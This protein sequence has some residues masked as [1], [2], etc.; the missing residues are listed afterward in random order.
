[1]SDPA[2]IL[3]SAP[4]RSY[5]F[6][7]GD[8]P[9]LLGKV[10]DAGA[11]AV[12]LDLE[13]AVPEAHKVQARV[14]VAEALAAEALAAGNLP[15]RAS[16]RPTAWVRING[17]SAGEDTG[18]WEEDVRAVVRPGLGGVRV[19][20]SESRE[21][22]D[23][24]EQALGAAEAA[25]AMAPG[26]IRV[27]C[28]IESA[29]GLLV[30]GELA[31]HPRVDRLAFGEADFLADIGA[32]GDEEGWATLAARSQIVVASRHAGIDAPVAPVYTLLDDAQGLARSSEQNRRLGFFGR[33]C[34]H[35]RQLAVV[36]QV[37]TPSDRALARAKLVLDVWK[38]SGSGAAVTEDGVFVDAAIV[39]RANA[40]LALAR[41][42]GLEAES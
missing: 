21:Q 28:T 19:P 39:R 16:G 33:S 37:F 18:R 14:Q 17:L 30:A 25:A 3:G 7:P 5:L 34:I 13:D 2:A 31:E 40:L 8:Q 24:L 1:M 11:D 36:H 26:T 38:R 9:H 29:S 15:G 4:A 23:Q 20:K 10:F 22:L 42:I 6:A 27:M 41:A 35:P 32:D 12:V